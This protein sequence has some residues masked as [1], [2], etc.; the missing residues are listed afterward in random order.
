MEKT[1]NYGINLG[2]LDQSSVPDI[3]NSDL[4]L[5]LI[6]E[7]RRISK[8]KNPSFPSVVKARSTEQLRN[9]RTSRTFIDTYYIDQNALDTPGGLGHSLWRK[10]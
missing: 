5:L 3:S 8:L 9:K 7:L 6:S 1:Y 4:S 10:I 2:T